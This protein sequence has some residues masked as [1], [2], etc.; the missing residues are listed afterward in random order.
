MREPGLLEA[1]ARLTARPEAVAAASEVPTTLSRS[2]RGSL[3]FARA[4][5]EVGNE[6][7]DAKMLLRALG[8]ECA[9]VE[10]ITTPRMSATTHAAA[11]WPKLASWPSPADQLA[12]A[13]QHKVPTA[14]RRALPSALHTR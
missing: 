6:V 10:D 5:L 14:L 13:G 12:A 8:V 7:H 9:V 4:F 2:L 11:R 1:A 3:I